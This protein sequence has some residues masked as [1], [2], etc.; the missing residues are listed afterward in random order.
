MQSPKP[1]LLLRGGIDV[2]VRG[3]E[4]AIQLVYSISMEVMVTPGRDLPHD[5]LTSCAGTLKT[6]A[7][8]I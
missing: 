5:L 3:A 1:Y 8:T 4:L 7:F 2:K 6:I